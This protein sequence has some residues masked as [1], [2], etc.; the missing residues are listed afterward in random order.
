MRYNA[1]SRHA[2]GVSHGWIE[3]KNKTSWTGFFIKIKELEKKGKK[4]FKKLIKINQ[5]TKTK[6]KKKLKKQLQS[7]TI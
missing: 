6:K 2:Y 4:Y 3:K 1:I 5:T 7:S